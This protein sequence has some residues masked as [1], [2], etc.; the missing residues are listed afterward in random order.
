MVYGVSIMGVSLIYKAL[1]EQSDLCSRL[2]SDEKIAVVFD[3]FF[4]YG[5]PFSRR[6]RGL[7]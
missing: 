2:K 5:H 3:A 7:R 4:D 6:P 1:P